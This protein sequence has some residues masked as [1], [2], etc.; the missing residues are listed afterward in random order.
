MEAP[1]MTS[2]FDRLLRNMAAKEEPIPKG[3]STVTDYATRWDKSLPRTSDV[4]RR[5]LSK[6]LAERRQVLRRCGNKTMKVWVYR[7]AA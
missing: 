5:A 4:L 6:N 2:E 3:F 7:V 1:D